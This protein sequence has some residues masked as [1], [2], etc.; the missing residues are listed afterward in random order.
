MLS[1]HGHPEFP[2]VPEPDQSHPATTPW[3]ALVACDGNATHA[4]QDI[5]VFTL[6]NNSGAVGAVRIISLCK[7][8]AG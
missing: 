5:D 4:S 6:A 7:R 8:Q 2:A 3:I 1:D